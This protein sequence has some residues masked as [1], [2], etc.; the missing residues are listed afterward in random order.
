L[1]KSLT[2]LK[3]ALAVCENNLSI[4]SLKH[5]VSAGR[6]IPVLVD[7]ILK[8]Q[9]DV[10][11]G[12]LNDQI[13]PDDTKE[14]DCDLIAAAPHKLATVFGASEVS[15][16]MVK[17]PTKLGVERFNC[18]Q[19][20]HGDTNGWVISNGI[21]LCLLEDVNVPFAVKE[22]TRIV[23]VHF[24]RLRQGLDRMMANSGKIPCPARK[25]AE[26]QSRAKQAVMPLGVC[27]EHVPS[28]EVKMCSELHRNMQK[29]TETIS[30][31]I[32]YLCF[33]GMSRLV[34][35]CNTKYIHWRPH[36][37]RNMVPLD[38]DRF[39]INQDAMV[40]LIGWAGNMTLSNA[41][42]QGVLTS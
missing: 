25:G 13:R 7:M 27:N 15:A 34:T 26:G 41:F 30:S 32:S 20:T 16:V 3:K 18:R 29:L 17:V 6:N 22:T 35:D 33:T 1:F 10:S 5:V 31:V 11:L 8:F 14:V 37:R 36:S 2:L 4:F 40:R 9:G 42:L 23:Q 38:P 39:S 21:T 12:L 19:V 28:T 24:T